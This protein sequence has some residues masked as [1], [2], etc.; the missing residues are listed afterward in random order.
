MDEV[1]ADAAPDV[2]DGAEVEP[3]DM[4]AIGGL[5]VDD[6]LP[7]RALE[8]REAKCVVRIRGGWMGSDIFGRDHEARSLGCGRPAG[9]GKNIRSPAAREG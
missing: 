2:E 1:A 8:T 7:S 3:S 9:G 6:P 4:P 5:D